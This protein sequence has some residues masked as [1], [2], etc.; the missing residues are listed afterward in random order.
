[1]STWLEIRCENLY[2][3]SFGHKPNERCWS[4]DGKSPNS[5]SD[6]GQADVMLT[7]RRISGEARAA[8]W[9]K[10]REGW[11]CPYCQGLADT[12]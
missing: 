3:S 10:K 9:V 2:D 1:M 4:S 11:L 8:G 6:D 7:L 5:V 12:N